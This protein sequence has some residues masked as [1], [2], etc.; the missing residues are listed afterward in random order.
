M[1]ANPGY[2]TDVLQA[3]EGCLEQGLMAIE[4][5][6]LL[7]KRRDMWSLAKPRVTAGRQVEQAMVQVSLQQFIP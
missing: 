3:M 6:L 7:G 1:L 2:S 4:A 5:A